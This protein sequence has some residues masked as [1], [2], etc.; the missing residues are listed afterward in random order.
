MLQDYLNREPSDLIRMGYNTLIFVVSSLSG[1]VYF[2]VTNEAFGKLY[3]F[4]GFFLVIL[5]G[6]YWV[7][8]KWYSV[9]MLDVFLVYF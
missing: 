5:Y 6:M 2:L 8:S 9:F 4:V 3:Y 7:D 1:G